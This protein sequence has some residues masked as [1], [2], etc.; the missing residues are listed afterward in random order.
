M[1]S[2]EL[3]NISKTY[4]DGSEQIEVL[5]NINLKTKPGEFVAIVGPSGAGKSTFLTIAGALLKPSHGSIKINNQDI[6]VATN[7]NL[8]NIRLDEI[9]FIFQSSELI[10]YLQAEDQLNIVSKMAHKT[11]YK[12]N[13]RKLLENVGLLDQKNKYPSQLSGGQK[14]RIAIARAL[15]NDPSLILADEPTASLDS[16]RGRQIVTMLQ[17]I[18]HQE[19]K[20]VVMVTHDERVL[21]LVDKIYQIEDGLLFVK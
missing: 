7:R 8:S 12:E 9:G 18:S 16:K 11:N 14:Q 17:E 2:L 10:P 1:N 6:T 3:E 21:D 13:N 4:L 19:N 15:V 5:K 20:S